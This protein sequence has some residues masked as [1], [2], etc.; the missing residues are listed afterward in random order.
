MPGVASLRAG[1]Y[2]AHPRNAFWP[3]MDVLL[4]LPRAAPY[5]ER[6]AGLAAA[7]VALWDVLA[8][9][10]RPGSLDGAIVP[11]SIVVNPVARLCA[12]HPTLAVIALNGGTAARLFDRHVQGMLAMGG[13]SM[14]VLRLPSTSP[15]HAAR[16]FEQ[17][18]EAWRVVSEALVP[19]P[20]FVPRQPG[21]PPCK[22][23]GASG[24]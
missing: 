24:P 10:D 19:T 8:Q 21:A 22:P 13:R 23:E 7:G 1:E 17:K 9:C 15:A 16:T 12:E 11:G 5:D 20:H 3:L 6:M 14:R 18:R 2:Y 4:G